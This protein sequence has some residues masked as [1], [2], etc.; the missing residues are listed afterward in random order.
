[1]EDA[2]HKRKQ[3]LTGLVG[4]EVIIPLGVTTRDTEDL[5][6]VGSIGAHAS[7]TLALLA[8]EVQAI[9]WGK[10]LALSSAQLGVVNVTRINIGFGSIVKG[11]PVFRAGGGGMDGG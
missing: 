2:Y 10:A 4:F 1:M 7:D 9:V 6:W 11:L 5:A 8:H 3:I